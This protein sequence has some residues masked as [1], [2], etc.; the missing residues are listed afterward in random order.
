M[1]SSMTTDF[2]TTEGIRFVEQIKHDFFLQSKDL[3]LIIHVNS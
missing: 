1:F 3:S 2:G